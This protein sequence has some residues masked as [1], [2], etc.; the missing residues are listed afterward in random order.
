MIIPQRKN[1]KTP[2]ISLIEPFNQ[3]QNSSQASV[4]KAFKVKNPY[5]TKRGYFPN[6]ATPIYDVDAEFSEAPQIQEL[7]QLAN[8]LENDI[9]GD[10]DIEYL[11]D[12]IRIESLSFCRIGLIC[13]KI[14]SLKLFKKVSKTF[15]DFCET[16]LGY[17]VWYVNRLIQAAT[18]TMELAANNFSI[19]PSNEAQ[20]RSLL[21]A[22]E[23]DVVNAWKSVVK[24]LK[25]HEITAKSIRQHLKPEEK[26]KSKEEKIIVS[27]ELHEAMLRTAAKIGLSIT[28]FLTE[29]F[30]PVVKNCDNWYNDRKM[31]KW[32]DDLENLVKNHS[33]SA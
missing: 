26:D 5:Q 19:L 33:N 1:P 15:K 28:A 10:F 21:Y 22:S 18:T 31:I 2:G 12:R 7:I 6:P 17:S 9:E 14:K 3:V 27:S 4:P 8:D 30:K 24:D 29:L 13:F 25:P 32:E 23:G 16:Q 11:I 20:A